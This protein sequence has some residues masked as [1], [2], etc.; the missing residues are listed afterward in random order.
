[1]KD[2]DLKRW[3]SILVAL[4]FFIQLTA[5]AAL[6][7]EAD[8]NSET[9]VEFETTDENTDDPMDES[10]MTDESDNSDTN[11]E[12]ESNTAVELETE[13]ADFVRDTRHGRHLY[14][15]RWGALTRSGQERCPGLTRE[16]IVAALEA[17]ESPDCDV[18]KAEYDGSLAVSKGQLVV[19]KQ[20]LFED[21]DDVSKSSGSSVEWHSMIAGHWDGL[22]IEYTP[23]MT[24][25]E[26]VEIT[27]SMGEVS[28]TYL[29]AEAK[30]R[31]EIGNGHILE[32]RPLAHSLTGIRSEL[33]DKLVQNKLDVQDEVSR[34]RELI[35]RLRLIAST[36]GD[37]A[38]ETVSNLEEA[39]EEIE[40]YNFDDLSN[41]EV[42]AAIQEILD[43]LGDGT[44]RD[45][46]RL[47]ISRLKNKVSNI[48]DRAKERKFNQGFT[49]FRDTDDDQWYTNYVSSAKEL[50]IVS[51]YKD[52]N[53]N[54]LGEYRPANN[55]T[56][57][58]ILKI[59]LETS[60]RG[61]SDGI[62]SLAGAINHWAKAYVKRAEELGLNLVNDEG[63][64]LS[65]PATRGEVIRM[66]LEAIGVDAEIVSTT[67]FSDLPAGHFH[68]A[69]IEFAV[70]NGIISGDDGANTVRPDEPINRAEVAKI[71][72]K[73]LEY[74][75]EQ[76]TASI[77]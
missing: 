68:A 7:L 35:R 60:N 53:G 49:P 15:V 16:E 26:P 41:D 9:D 62:P 72:K 19:K 2:L 3:G 22:I 66:V 51:G 76:Q 38:N 64:D 33:H 36:L 69:F 46:L 18:V 48:K 54:E 13:V 52:A 37:E 67:S 1:M 10:E 39:L 28:G 61:T 29:P 59:G 75:L 14:Q 77:Q 27:L 73:V 50:G 11:M 65:R 30:G 43:G 56:V 21:N 8:V 12:V 70:E 34:L 42:E 6:A 31:H 44:T 58:E 4:A 57:A 74:L 40:I 63:I 47:M 25:D 45:T 55:V 23:D 24:S 5:P 71:V 17:G 20:I 32:I